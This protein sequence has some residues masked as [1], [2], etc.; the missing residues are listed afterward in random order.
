MLLY[1]FPNGLFCKKYFR[2][3]A[4]R[5]ASHAGNSHV[6]PSPNVYEMSSDGNSQA[7]PSLLPESTQPVRSGIAPPPTIT[8][9]T[10]G[11]TLIDND[12]YARSNDTDQHP[13]TANN[14]PAPP[15]YA[16]VHKNRSGKFGVQ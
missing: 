11:I 3:R 13:T 5:K 8:N 15:V 9:L 4:S 12:L 7:G 2:R 10:D 16:V 6:E 1:L 14:A